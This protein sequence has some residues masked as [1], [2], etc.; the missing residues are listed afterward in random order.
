MCT[1]ACVRVCVRACVRACV[2]ACVRACVCVHACVCGHGDDGTQQT[3]ETG[4]A[5]L[6]GSILINCVCVCVCAESH[7]D[8]ST[9][10]QMTLVWQLCVALWG[11]PEELEEDIG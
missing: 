4:V 1:C 6:H 8:A 3:D 5:A 7:G 11:S 2:C 9:Q 10:R